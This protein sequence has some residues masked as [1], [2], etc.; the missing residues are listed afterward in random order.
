LAV[1]LAECS[2]RLIEALLGQTSKISVTGHFR[3][4]IRAP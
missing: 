1:G 4:A 3:F 2:Y